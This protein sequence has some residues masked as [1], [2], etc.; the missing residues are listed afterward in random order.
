MR[1][2]PGEDSRRD[3]TGNRRSMFARQS[4]SNLLDRYKPALRHSAHDFVYFRRSGNDKSACPPPLAFSV[5][6]WADLRQSFIVSELFLPGLLFFS[7][8]VLRLSFTPSN[9]K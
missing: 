9:Q 1:R 3:R 7:H 2:D 6:N 5:V 4:A 8:M